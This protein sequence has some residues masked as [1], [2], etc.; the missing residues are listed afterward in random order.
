M[1][2]QAAV[3]DVAFKLMQQFMTSIDWLCEGGGIGEPINF[4]I[5]ANFEDARV[6]LVKS[7]KNLVKKDKK[8]KK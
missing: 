6:T 1:K 3:A 2:K 7:N 5:L 8:K 4:E